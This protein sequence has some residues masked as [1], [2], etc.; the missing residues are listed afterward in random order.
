M[1]PARLSAASRISAGIVGALSLAALLLQYVLLVQLTRDNVGVA[2]GTLRFFSY[3]TIL[4]NIAVVA[5]AWTA[6]AGGTGFF[7]RPRV[8]AA[9]AL[10]IGVTGCIYFFILRHLWQP[11]G[12]QWWADTGLHY[13]APLAY[14]AW[15]LA[16]VPHGTLSARD[17]LA[18]LSFPLAYV[19]WVFVRG[20]WVGEYPYPFID[21][22]QLGWARV[23]VNAVGV[24]GVFVVLGLVLLGLD[25]MLGRGRRPLPP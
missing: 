14:C 16:C 6:A 11:Q 17:V 7:A 24:L 5:V 25:R 12:A 21:V 1:S 22:G 4:S 19:I 2:F 13:A 20:A 23:G 3:F 15:W 18:W 10:Y 9:V 8:R